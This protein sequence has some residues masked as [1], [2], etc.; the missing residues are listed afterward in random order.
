MRMALR[1]S[2]GQRMKVSSWNWADHP[3]DKTRGVVIGPF[4]GVIAYVYVPTQKG[5]YG[6][7][8]QFRR[9]Q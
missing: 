3:T 4:F 6:V 5:K 2:D 1:G 9:S 8:V 7:T